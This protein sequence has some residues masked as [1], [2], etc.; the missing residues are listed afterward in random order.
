MALMVAII[1]FVCLCAAMTRHQKDVLGRKLTAQSTRRLR[2]AGGTF[3][4]CAL[5]MDLTALGGG[6][7][8]VTWCGHL[9]VGAALVLTGLNWK[10]AR[11]K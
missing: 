8:A 7:G 1:G 9:T 10:V 5:A 2:A 4:I 11:G 6:Y 3:L